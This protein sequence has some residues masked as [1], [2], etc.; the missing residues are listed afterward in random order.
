MSI[1][2]RIKEVFGNQSELARQIDETPQVVSNWKCRGRIPAE[3]CKA[4]AEASNGQI[5]LH[6]LRPD[7]YEAA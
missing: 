6:E 1:F 2:N 7:I 5:S 3:K 4:I